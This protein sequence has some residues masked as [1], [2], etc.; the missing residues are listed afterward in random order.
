[1]L[2]DKSTSIVS[3]WINAK[4]QPSKPSLMIERFRRIL[5]EFNP[6]LQMHKLDLRRLKI[7]SLF[8]KRESNTSV[9]VE[10]LDTQLNLVADYLNTSLN[11]IQNNYNRHKTQLKTALN[12]LQ[13]VT[14]EMGEMFEDF[15]IASIDLIED[16]LKEAPKK[17][18]RYVRKTLDLEQHRADY[19]Q[20]CKE[21]EKFREEN[22]SH[23]S[24][25]ELYGKLVKKRKRVKGITP[26]AEEIA[27]SMVMI[28]EKDPMDTVDDAIPQ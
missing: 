3:L 18:Q 17:F 5:K 11:C 21:F 19:A 8:E 4:G 7:S 26:Q 15:K 16:S 12:L 22:P 24:F 6:C 14:K 13:P 9:P 28:E 25:D 20:W 23:P 27:D 10:L 2:K 1:M